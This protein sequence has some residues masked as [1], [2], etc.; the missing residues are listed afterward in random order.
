M[1]L[2]GIRHLLGS[3]NDH[4]EDSEQQALYVSTDLNAQVLTLQE[5]DVN[6]DGQTYRQLT[7]DYFAWLRSRMQTA[8][9]AHRN[10]RISDKN[11][12]ILRERFNP[13]QHH[14]IEMFGQDALKT[15]C[16]NFNSNR[17]QPPQDFLE[18]RW[19]YPQN[20]TL[21][22]SADVKSSAVA[23]VDAIRSQAMDLGWTEPQLYQN[24]GRHRFPCGGDYGLICFVGSDRKIGEVTESYIGIV[25][26]IGTARERV[27]KFHNSKVMQPWMKKVE[28]PH[29]H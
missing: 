1:F 7:P 6:H 22:F 19:I 5:Q 9:S 4:D 14:A 16:E 10:K 25:H 2:E 27:L 15:A 12:N 3:S 29:V 11:W 26:G 28:V 17:Y 23:K 24:Q 18:E 20:E 8:Q 21:K 13:I